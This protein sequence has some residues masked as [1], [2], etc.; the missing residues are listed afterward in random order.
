MS[1]YPTAPPSYQPG[2]N[3]KG[4]AATDEAAHPLLGSSPGPSSGGAIYDEPTDLP[5]D[6]KVCTCTMDLGLRIY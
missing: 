5:D 6:F 4:Y 3:N 2:A 1:N